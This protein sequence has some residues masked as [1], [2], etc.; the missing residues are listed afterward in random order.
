MKSFEEKYLKGHFS[1][2]NVIV[3]RFAKVKEQFNNMSMHE[4]QH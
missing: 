3:K 4:F 1:R 2:F